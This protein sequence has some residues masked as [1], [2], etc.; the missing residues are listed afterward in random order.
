ML[1][2]VWFSIPNGT[3]KK[4]AQRW[5]REALVREM[6]NIEIEKTEKGKPRI[7]GKEL[8]VSISYTRF[9]GCIAISD[10]DLGVD[11]EY[12]DDQF[13]WEDLLWTLT[14]REKE[15]IFRIEPTKR[16]EA[17]FHIWTKKEAFVKLLGTGFEVPPEEIETAELERY[18]HV[19]S[20]TLRHQ[21]K[22]FVWSL[23]TR[24]G[25]EDDEK[26]ASSV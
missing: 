16:R 12:L 18:F 7:K 11:I 22:R 19:V 20:K 17:F 14:A 21:N 3:K 15:I 6:G 24:R 13:P 10:Q 23:I 5:A 1:K 9:L 26:I 2:L 25:M 8:N 4:E